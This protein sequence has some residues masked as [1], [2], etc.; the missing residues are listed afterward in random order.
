[1]S[2]QKDTISLFSQHESFKE[3]STQFSSFFNSANRMYTN[4]CLSGSCRL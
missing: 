1:M 2:N 3:E 4:W